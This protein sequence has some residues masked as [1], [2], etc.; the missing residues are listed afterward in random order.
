MSHVESCKVQFNN[1][2]AVKAACKALGV[3]FVENAK[4][5]AWYGHHVGDYPISQE[6]KD[7]GVTKSN[8][9]SCSHKIKVPGSE[10]E[11]GLYEVQGKPGVFLPL[12][13]FFGTGRNIQTAL[14]KKNANG[15]YGKGLEK[16]ADT[17]SVEVLKAKARSKGYQFREVNAGGKIKLVVTL[18]N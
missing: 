1:L 14:C 16:L 10:Y 2:T 15:T 4:T 7:A 11:I 9:G 6:M 18:G 17:Y 3:E 13:D 8:L 5:Y 12:Y